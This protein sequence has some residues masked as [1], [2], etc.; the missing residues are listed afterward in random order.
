MNVGVP[1]PVAAG[2]VLTSSSAWTIEGLLV[3][4]NA[5]NVTPV[6]I[7]HSSGVTYTVPAGKILYLAGFNAGNTGSNQSL[8]DASGV[9]YAGTGSSGGFVSLSTPAP[10]AAGT[11]LKCSTTTRGAS[12]DT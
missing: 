10:V 12:R 2:T 5:T 8:T 11:V 9:G 6:A 1:I 4:T 7:T 3:P